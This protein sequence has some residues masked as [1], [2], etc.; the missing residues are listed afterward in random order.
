MAAL[1]AAN[2]RLRQVVEAKDTEIAALRAALEAAHAHQEELIRRQA[3][4]TVVV[5]LVQDPPGSTLEMGG[6]A[7]VSCLLCS[8]SPMAVRPRR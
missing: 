6:R 8:T 1:R 7:G 3:E 2:A 4:L 5:N